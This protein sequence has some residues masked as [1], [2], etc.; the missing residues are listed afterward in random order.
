MPQRREAALRAGAI[1]AA[2]GATYS[3]GSAGKAAS[4]SPV[5]VGWVNGQGGSPS[6]PESTTALNAA[7]S[8]INQ[9]E[10]GADGHPIKLI[11]C[12]VVS[13]EAQGQVCGQQMVNN[14]SI[15]AILQGGLDI[16]N[17]SLQTT[18][19]GS[20][21]I[22]LISASPGP[23][24]VAKN[25]YA[26]NSAPISAIAS[27]PVY[28]KKIGIKTMAQIVANLPADQQIA[29]VVNAPIKAE[30]IKIKQATFP[31][32]STDLTGALEASGVATANVSSPVVVTPAACIDYAKSMQQLGLSTPT[33][34]SSLCLTPNI[35]QALGDYPKWTYQSAILNIAA[36]DP[37]GQV[38]I[39]TRPSW[40][41][42]PARTL[43]WASTPHT[44]SEPGLHS[45][46]CSTRPMPRS[47]PR[48]SR[49]PR[50]H[51]PGRYCSDRHRSTSAASSRCPPSA[52]PRVALGTYKGNGDWVNSSGWIY[53]AGR[54]NPTRGSMA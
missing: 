33:L 51:S 26:L 15:V 24:T 12:Y 45:P 3:G 13:A 17:Q 28:M 36:P 1:N 11:S 5:Y 30:G 9:N 10:D 37:T 20:K 23:D 47:P 19:N 40:P 7:L 16:G 2:L 27:M 43:S 29:Q 14:K 35:K 22:I 48:P 53:Q 4:G 52:Q 41:S 39:G 32:N 50:R 49:R 46:R 42:T 6:D 44:H 54:T 31:A 8:Y 34:A 21:P 18:I 25:A 38:K